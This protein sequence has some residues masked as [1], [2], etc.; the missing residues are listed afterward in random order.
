MD[1]LA[2]A[3]RPPIVILNINVGLTMHMFSIE[4]QFHVSAC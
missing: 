2:F 1:V 4:R 3:S